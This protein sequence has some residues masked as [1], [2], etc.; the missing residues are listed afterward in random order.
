M[1]W[2]T[3]SKA[4]VEPGSFARDAGLKPASINEE[5]RTAELIWSTGAEVR[6]NSMHGTYLERLSMDARHVDMRRLNSGKAPVLNGHRNGSAQDIIGVVVS[7]RIENGEGIAVV[8]FSDRSDVEPLWR[9]I[10]AGIIRNISVGYHVHEFAESR[11]KDSEPVLTAVRWEP[12]EISVVPIPADADAYI[13]SYGAGVSDGNNQISGDD[14][15]RIAEIQG[16]AKLGGFGRDVADNLVTRGLSV[17]AARKELMQMR[18]DKIAADYEIQ[19]SHQMGYGVAADGSSWAGDERSMR[20]AAMSDAIAARINPGSKAPE[21]LAREYMGKT[22]PDLCR[23]ILEW[24]GESTLGFEPATIVQ[25]TMAGMHTSSDFQEVL[26]EVANKTLRRNYESAPCALKMIARQTTARDFREKHSILVDG[27]G[28]LT[29]LNEHAEIPYSTIEESSQA[30]KVRPFGTRFAISYEAM[31]NDDLQAFT[32]HMRLAT[33]WAYNTESRKFIDILTANSGLGPSMNDDNKTLFHADHGNLAGSGAALSVTTLG[34]ARQAMRRQT[35]LDGNDPIN[36]TPKFLVVPAS[37][38]T[39]AEQVLTGIQ[40]TKVDDVNPH[41][42]KLLL[43][44]DP[45][46]D[47]VSATA[48]YLAAD[49]YA[50]D[51]IEYAYL[52]GQDGPKV[53]PHKAFNKLGMEFRVVM[54]FG[55][56]AIDWR[57]MYKNPGA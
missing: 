49:P 22:I 10:V 11:G 45:R 39:V 38:E 43:V 52:D 3:R 48:W 21:G 9:D 31:V 19:G 2:Q 16:L 34:A 18:D 51:T 17:E 42:G 25:R 44:V 47:D 28:E 41:A 27:S 26:G 50:F 57:G 54:F 12:M 30:Y 1:F 33:K 8:R 13:R 5:D 6:R 56:G 55:V 24:N 35:G 23:T 46:L 7:A 20:R 37:L 15:S 36:V 53:E 29:E 14:K 40:A 32:N 4:S